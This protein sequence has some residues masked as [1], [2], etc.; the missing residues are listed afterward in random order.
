MAKEAKRRAEAM[1][2]KV[3]VNIFEEVVGWLRSWESGCNGLC[4]VGLR[5]QRRVRRAIYTSQQAEDFNL[6]KLQ[7]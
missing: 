3:R 2:E 5:K 6:F 7:S 1:V 4:F